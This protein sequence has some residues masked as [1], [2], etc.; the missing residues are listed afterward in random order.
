MPRLLVHG[1]R[2]ASYLSM[3]PLFA[4]SLFR[5]EKWSNLVQIKHAYSLS[6]VSRKVL[7][8]DPQKV[9]A[10]LPTDKVVFFLNVDEEDDNVEVGDHAVKFGDCFCNVCFVIGSVEIGG[11]E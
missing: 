1:S 6:E 11:Y 10:S 8:A 4:L 9:I 3:K 2:V 7:Y 5:E